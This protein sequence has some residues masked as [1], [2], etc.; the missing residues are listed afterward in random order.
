MQKVERNNS[1][2]IFYKNCV[3]KFNAGKVLIIGDL[4]LDT[5]LIG[6]STRISPEA[7]IPIVKIE[8]SKEMLGG[9][10][11]VARSIVALGGSV[12]IFGVTGID[13][14]AKRMKKLF[15][16][17]KIASHFLALE[18]RNTTIKT[19]VL[20]RGQQ[21][22]RMD[23]ETS[24]ALE[25]NRRE[26]FT[27]LLENE[28]KKF[29]VVV[30]SDYAKGLITQELMDYLRAFKNE[31]GNALKILADPKPENKELY[32]NL[33]LLTPNQKETFEL[34]HKKVGTLEEVKEAGHSLK[35]E[36]Q[37]ENILTTLG[38]QGMALFSKNENKDEIWHIPT[39]AQQVFDVTG[40]GDTVIA[41]IALALSVGIDLL[42]ASVLANFAAG[43]VVGKIG[44][45][46]ASQ[47]ELLLA[48]E[49]NLMINE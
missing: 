37:L 44:S 45:A 46:T 42:D 19:R 26:E 9:A 6:D 29:D 22:L 13:D 36:L 12:S 33:F 14:E 20:A 11:N 28:L 7:P 10:G 24:H 8:Q 27:L 4:M 47:E 16:D 1:S 30:I 43:I 17:E 3:E 41:T 32:K 23:R 38:P 25:K 5:Y 21:M 40:A 15:A 31:K 39:T 18:N 34:S 35:Q 2:V 48:V 49:Q